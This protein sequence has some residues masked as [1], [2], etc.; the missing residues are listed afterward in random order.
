M[1]RLGARHWAVLEQDRVMLEGLSDDANARETLYQH[2]IGV[3]RMR[4]HLKT[5]ARAQISA[6]RE[7]AAQPVVREPTLA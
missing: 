4:R 3:T 2:D 1:N 6:A 7:L 5:L